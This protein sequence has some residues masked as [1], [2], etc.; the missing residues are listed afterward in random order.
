M[1]CQDLPLYVV[2]RYYP[3]L[4]CQRCDVGTSRRLL[5]SAV[6]LDLRRSIIVCVTPVV[7]RSFKGSPMVLGVRG[8]DPTVQDTA[9]IRH[10]ICSCSLDNPSVPALT[11]RS[12]RISRLKP[13]RP[14]DFLSDPRKNRSLSDSCFSLFENFPPPLL[15]LNLGRGINTLVVGKPL[16]IGGILVQIMFPSCF[17]PI[18]TV[19]PR[20]SAPHNDLLSGP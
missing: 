4:M 19:F 2:S 12:I 6:G 13:G 5:Y 10:R 16:H 18:P 9:R 3:I 20:I 8:Y 14:P 17:I 11:P 1:S 15:I 7:Y